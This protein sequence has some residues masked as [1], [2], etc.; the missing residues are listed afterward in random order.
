MLLETFVERD[1]F[2][3]TSY[4]AANWIHVGETAGRG[5]LDRQNKGPTTSCK[6]VWVYPLDRHFR[7][8]LRGDVS[9]PGAR[10]SAAAGASSR[11]RA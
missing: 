1:R 8:I 7:E 10:G 9:P 5:K 11:R 6:S 4:R 3:G 2:A